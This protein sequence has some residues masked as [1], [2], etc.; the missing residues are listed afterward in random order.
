MSHELELQVRKMFQALDA[1]DLP[2]LYSELSDDVES[3]DELTQK[4]NRGRAAVE[5]AF[6]MAASAISDIKS[7]LS[8]FNVLVAGEMAMVTCLLKQSYVYEGQHV[9]LV[10][11]TT[12]VSRLEHGSW[13]FVLLHSV[14]FA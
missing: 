7:E 9:E 11:P 1:L 2:A 4:W 12:C 10:A 13:K 8:D 6:N 14:P 5:A 3:V